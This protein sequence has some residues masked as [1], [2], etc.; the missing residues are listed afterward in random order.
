MGVSTPVNA[1]CGWSCPALL[2][3]PQADLSLRDQDPLR[4]EEQEAGRTCPPTGWTTWREQ[5]PPPTPRLGQRECRGL[6][7]EPEASITL[8]FHS[9]P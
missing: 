8:H 5:S 4:S 1:G 2:A 6:D 7:P 9:C 3:A